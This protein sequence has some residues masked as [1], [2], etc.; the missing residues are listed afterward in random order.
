MIGETAHLQTLHIEIECILLKETCKTPVQYMFCY[1]KFFLTETD[2]NDNS[3]P[4]V[5][6]SGNKYYYWFQK[7]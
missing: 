7:E 5:V 3:R 2:H 6:M 4:V 1:F